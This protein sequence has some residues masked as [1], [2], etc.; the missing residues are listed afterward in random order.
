MRVDSSGI[1]VEESLRAIHAD[2]RGVTGNAA[3]LVQPGPKFRPPLLQPA[4]AR[5]NNSLL[6]TNETRRPQ[7]DRRD[8]VV[9]GVGGHW[10]WLDDV[11]QCAQAHR[12]GG[13]L[14]DYR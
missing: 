1:T 7:T 3:E 6:R 11:A 8:R 4:A 14:G 9:D 13:R 5:G 2:H 12:G 10:R